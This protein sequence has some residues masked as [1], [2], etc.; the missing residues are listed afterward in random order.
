[1]LTLSSGNAA[2]LGFNITRDRDDGALV[3]SGGSAGTVGG[4]L[5]LFAG[6]YGGGL[7]NRIDFQ[8]GSNTVFLIDQSTAFTLGVA[9]NA[10]AHTWYGAQWTFSAA[11]SST[12]DLYS[13]GTNDDCV[14]RIFNNGSSTADQYLQ[15]FE[16]GASATGWCIGRD[17][18]DSGALA[19]SLGA[20]LGTS[21]F[22]KITTAGLVSIG[23]SGGGQRHA[24][25]IGAATNG[26]VAL[27]MLNGPT[28]TSGNPAKWIT[29]TI[30]GT[31]HVIP[32]WSGA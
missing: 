6:S 1:M 2:G 24:L 19:V 3:L 4:K 26:A 5:R 30:D 15:L 18:S 14:L 23:A 21:N 20:A 22:L 25:N 29:I 31:N 10:Q 9:A 27:T 32:A 8:Q 17:D 7:N 11:D 16:G 12:L 28:G 13:T